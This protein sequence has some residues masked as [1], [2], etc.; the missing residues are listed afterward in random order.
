MSTKE[1]PFIIFGGRLYLRSEQTR[2]DLAEI[3]DSPHFSPKRNMRKVIVVCGEDPRGCDEFG[4]RL[5]VT[6]WRD[7]SDSFPEIRTEEQNRTLVLYRGEEP[8]GLTDPWPI[9]IDYAHATSAD[10]V[11]LSDCDLQIPLATLEMLVLDTLAAQEG[12][13]RPVVGVPYRINRYLGAYDVHRCVDEDLENAF[14]TCA[15]EQRCP[16]EARKY[17]KSFP[18]IDKQPGAFVLTRGA[19][20]FLHE[21]SALKD[22][23]SHIGD[24]VLVST[25][26]EAGF[27]FYSARVTPNKP[28][29]GQGPDSSITPRVASEKM[30]QIVEWYGLD[31]DTVA[32]KVRSDLPKYLMDDWITEEH[33]DTR[34]KILHHLDERCE[35][36]RASLAALREEQDT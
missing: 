24:L 26:A 34:D 2:R 11:V 9:L 36:Y 13:Q 4:D 10:A 32:D 18:V 6:D 14:I 35:M 31:F 7:S 8:L 23:P 30:A 12:T 33:L 27:E 19:I 29:V 3:A 17:Y 25:L 22:K 1:L 16:D 5:V 21:R 28:R 20:E 15:F